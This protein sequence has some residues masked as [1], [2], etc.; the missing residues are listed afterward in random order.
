MGTSMTFLPILSLGLE[1]RRQNNI[2]TSCCKAPESQDCRTSIV[3][4]SKQNPDAR[5]IYMDGC[6]DKLKTFLK[7]H[8]IYLLAAGMG[9]VLAEIMGMLCSLC[10]CCALKRIDDLK[11]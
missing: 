3:L 5:Y 9:I 1:A 10:L 4:K 6:A 7:D 8:L 2:P 11:A